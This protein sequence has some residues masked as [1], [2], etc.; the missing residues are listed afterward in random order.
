MDGSIPFAPVGGMFMEMSPE[1]TCVSSISAPLDSTT[2]V[3]AM[4]L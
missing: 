3:L 4:L 1:G 2:K